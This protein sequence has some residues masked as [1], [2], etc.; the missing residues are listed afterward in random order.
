MKIYEITLQSGRPNYFLP[1]LATLI[2]LADNEE[3]AREEVRTWLPTQLQNFNYPE[4]YWCIED[5]GPIR[6][7]V[8]YVNDF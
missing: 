5:R 4:D 2:V 8:I 3:K 6:S 1:F 7:G